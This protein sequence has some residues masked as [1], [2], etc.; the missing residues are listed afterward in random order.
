MYSSAAYILQ[1]PGVGAGATATFLAGVEGTLAAYAAGRAHG[2]YEAVPR[3][4]QLAAIE[5][6]GGLEAYVRGQGR[7][8]L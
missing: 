7:H 3:L 4:D 5:A 2:S 6:G 1:H 8:C